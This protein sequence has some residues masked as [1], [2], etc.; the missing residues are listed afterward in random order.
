MYGNVWEV[1]SDFAALDYSGHNDLGEAPATANRSQGVARGGAADCPVAYCRSALR[2]G[3]GRDVRESN[4]GFR[5]VCETGPQSAAS[6]SENVVSSANLVRTAKCSASSVWPGFQAAYAG[7]GRGDTRW[8]SAPGDA[9]NAWIAA[10]WDSPVTVR[11]I[12]V[13]QA[14]DRLAVI[15]IQSQLVDGGRWSELATLNK[16]Q[17]AAF[18]Y[19]KE[20]HDGNDASVNPVIPVTLSKPVQTRGLR[21]LVVSALKNETVSVFEFEAYGSANVPGNAPDA[22]SP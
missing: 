16:Q 4:L 3:G 22:N 11:E 19:G 21:L 14:Y 15:K 13:R 7:Y 8:N 18:K 20:G 9:K 6:K 10:H 5:V 17:I 12:I 2:S 1:C